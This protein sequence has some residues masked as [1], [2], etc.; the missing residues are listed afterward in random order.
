MTGM[1]FGLGYE[2]SA[3][4]AIIDERRNTQARAAAIAQ[5]NVLTFPDGD[6]SSH[7]EQGSVTT[8]TPDAERGANY[9]LARVRRDAPEVFERVQDARHIPQRSARETLHK[10]CPWS[11]PSPSAICRPPL[12]D[13]DRRHD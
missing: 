11:L 10:P 13:Y 3:I 12:I 4:D 2:K 8:L 6:R 9:L 5:Q 7:P 1:P